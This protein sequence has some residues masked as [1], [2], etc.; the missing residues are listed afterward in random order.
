MFV[1]GRLACLPQGG[2][3]H[4]QPAGDSAAILEHETWWQNGQLREYYMQDRVLHMLPTWNRKSQKEKRTCY[5]IALCDRSTLIQLK[6]NAGII[7]PESQQASSLG[8]AMT[9]R[10]K[11]TDLV[12][13]TCVLCGHVLGRSSRCKSWKQQGFG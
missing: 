4:Q 13:A 1:S 2:V 10:A 12:T 8:V 7:A 3:E 6:A 11:N 5:L 9:R